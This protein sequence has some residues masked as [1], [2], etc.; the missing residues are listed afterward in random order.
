MAQDLDSASWDDSVGE[1]QLD[2]V[3][4]GAAHDLTR[5]FLRKNFCVITQPGSVNWAP[6]NNSLNQGE[7]RAMAWHDVG[8]NGVAVLSTN[9]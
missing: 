8:H 7:V 6:I 5:G 4:S 3:R 1:G 9:P 2:P